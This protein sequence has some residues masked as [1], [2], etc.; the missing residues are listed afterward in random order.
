MLSLKILKAFSHKPPLA[1]LSNIL[2][3]QSKLSVMAG[4]RKSCQGSRGTMNEDRMIAKIL[5]R[6]IS[7]HRR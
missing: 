3:S 7:K 4:G 5:T 2:D 6:K 1:E